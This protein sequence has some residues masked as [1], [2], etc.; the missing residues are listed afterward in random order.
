MIKRSLKED[1]TNFLQTVNKLFSKKKRQINKSKRKTSLGKTSLKK[2]TINNLHSYEKKK[3]P[4]PIPAII[5]SNPKAK[6]TDIAIIGADSYCAAYCIKK[7]Q[8]FAVSIKDIQYQAKKKA[9]AET[10]LKS[11]I[12]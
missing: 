9:K 7:T 3:S 2:A 6:D 10:D 4:V 8:V 12:F 11:V 1:M 5:K